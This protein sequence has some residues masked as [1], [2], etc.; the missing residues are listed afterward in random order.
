MKKCDDVQRRLSRFIDGEMPE[1]KISDALLHSGSC[2]ECRMYLSSAFTMRNASQRLFSAP[3][4][5][6]LDD[7][8]R[9]IPDR[10]RTG[11]IPDTLPLWKR[12][13]AIPYPV[14]LAASLLF[15]LFGALLSEGLLRK[16]PPPPMQMIENIQPPMLP[17]VEVC[18]T[19]EEHVQ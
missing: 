2:R 10:R 17:I 18:A 15:I 4:T 19:T 16:Q 7:R 14:L 3:V 8:I 12:R 1:E 11:R 9:A 13:T 6:E 5:R